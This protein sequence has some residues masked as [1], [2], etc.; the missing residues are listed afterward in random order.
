MID[1]VLPSGNEKE[2]IAMAE[3]L[4]YSELCLAYP[5]KGKMES[6]KQRKLIDALQVKTGIILNLAHLAELKHYHEAKQFSNFTVVAGEEENRNI[7]EKTRPDGIFHIEQAKRKDYTYNRNSGLNAITGKIAH[8]NKTLILYSL[9]ALSTPATIGRTKQNIILSRKFKIPS[10]T[11]S[12]AKNPYEMRNPNDLIALFTVLGMAPGEAKNA[13]SSISE[14]I[15]E[16]KEKKQPGYVAEG[17][18]IVE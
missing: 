9:D 13:M 16:N 7:F 3:K 10:A 17:V 11:V 4:G 6:Q 15:K 1:L 18:Q 5:F 14:K 12:L 2:F 8:A